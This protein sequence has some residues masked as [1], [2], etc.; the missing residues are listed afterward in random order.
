[1]APKILNWTDQAGLEK[2]RRQ[3][4][5]ERSRRTIQDEG[6]VRLELTN[7][8]PFSKGGGA[9]CRSLPL[10]AEVGPQHQQRQLDFDLSEAA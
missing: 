4:W 7:P 5:T 3:G 10:E 1:V 9:T 6:C 8:A 2:L